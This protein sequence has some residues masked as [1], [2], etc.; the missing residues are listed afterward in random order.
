VSGIHA[1]VMTRAPVAGQTKTRLIPALGAEGA[2]DLHAA[3]LHDVLAAAETWARDS[4][5]SGRRVSVHVFIHPAGASDAFRRAGIRWPGGAAIHGQSGDSL[6]RRMHNAIVEAAAATGEPVLVFGSDLPLLGPEHL[7]EAARALADADAVF[8]PTPDGGYYLLGLRRPAPALFDRP[9]WGSA[10]VL[11]DSL[12][13]AAALGLRTVRIAP[14]P[15]VDIPADL[16]AVLRH[17]LAR[18]RAGSALALLRRW[19]AE[20]RIAPR[21]A[22]LAGRPR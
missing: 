17:P 2:R 22:Q 18:G 4:A 13:A 9:D 7:A 10:T 5:R 6:G 8:G 20:G 12:R 1:I 16:A 3:C 11:D 14:L 15:D 19:E 21:G